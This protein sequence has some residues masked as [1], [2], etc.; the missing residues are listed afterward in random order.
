MAA[1]ELKK[2]MPELAKKT[3]FLWVG[4]FPSNFYQFPMMKPA[5]LV[6]HPFP[7]CYLSS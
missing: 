2:T 6:R 7:L 5:E 4:I 1:D 3:T